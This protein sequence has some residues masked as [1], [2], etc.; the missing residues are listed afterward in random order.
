LAGCSSQTSI[1]T[2]SNKVWSKY[3]TVT[4]KRFDTGKMWTFE[5]APLDYFEKKYNFRPS[6]EW[7]SQ[8]RMSALKFAT[9]C[10]SSFVSEDGLIMT[11][12]HCVDF[13]TDQI[14][15]E[16]ENIKKN[17]FYAETLEDERPVSRVFV[18]QLVLIEDVTDEVIEVIESGKT[19]QEKIE[20]KQ[21]KISEIE[22]LYSEESGLRCIVVS[23]YNG[24]KYSLYGYK[25]YTEVRAVFITESEVGL[26]GGDPDNFTYP[27]Y[28]LDCAFLRVY[29]D[30][31]NPLK[32]ENYFKWSPEGAQLGEPLFVVGNPASTKRLKT[33]AQ[34]EYY[35]DISYRNNAFVLNGLYNIYQEMMDE[36][37]ERKAEFENIFFMI[38][39]SAKA[40]S[41]QYK[42]LLDQYLMARKMDFEKKFK[43]AVMSDPN[44]K[45]MYGH[46]W[47]AIATARNEFRKYTPTISAYSLNPMITSEY[48][49]IAGSLVDLAKELE[50]PEEQRSDQYKENQLSETIESL[51]PDNFDELLNRKKLKLQADFITMNLGKDNPLVKK[52]FGGN[53]GDKAVLYVLDHSSITNKKDLV[54]LA[55]KGSNAVLNSDDPFIY[56]M[57]NTQEQLA[58]YQSIA[59]EIG[60]TEDVLEDELGQAL[61]AVYGTS[62]P[63][64]ATFTLRI[65]DG[66][67]M[68]YEY[69]GTEA[70]TF[71]TF[72]GLYDRYYSHKKE[73]PWDLPEKWL[74]PSE[75]FDLETPINFVTTHDIIGGSSGSAVI[76]KNGEIV[77]LA[78]DGNIESLPGDFIYT[79]K[80]NR[81]VAVASQGML[82]ALGEIYKARRLTK[83]LEMGKI[84]EEY[85]AKVLDE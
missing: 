23:L 83:E 27:R 67:M 33:I 8:V 39:N 35:K 48:F 54:E 13:V 9:W 18:D 2:Q 19:D 7:L 66:V 52:M 21:N 63:P 15:Q 12:H 3:D 40:V 36:A 45:E 24:G 55:N 34:L 73:Y 57:L 17:G 31:G 78:F 56:F 1:T 26:Y 81:M 51:F 75:D 47:D 59:E 49:M 4:A 58:N 16:N 72:Y 60:K 25:R 11:N 20:F 82:E 79:T 68:G 77:G 84:P 71:T 62:I 29:D 37:P 14:Q 76:N 32:T 10:T 65:G 43:A 30:D 28:N 69:N 50:L 22:K 85:L 41:G 44:L 61:F 5:D 6:E 64:D 70:P 53:D 42:G 80:A 46:L 38:S 74:N